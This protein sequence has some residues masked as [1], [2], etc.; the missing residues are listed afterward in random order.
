MNTWAMVFLEGYETYFLT[1][2]Q[3]QHIGDSPDSD[4]LGLL[5]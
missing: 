5:L 2:K 3:K 4:F 1:S